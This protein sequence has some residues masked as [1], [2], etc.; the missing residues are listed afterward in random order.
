MTVLVIGLSKDPVVEKVLEALGEIGAEVVHWSPRDLLNDCAFTVRDGTVEGWLLVGERLV[1]LDDIL[2]IFNRFSS[3]EMTPEYRELA[4]NDPLAKHALEAGARLMQWCDIASCVVMNRSSSNDANSAKAYQAQLISDYFFVP[5]T[6]ITNRVE[7]ALE[8]ASLY[9]RTI[10]KSCSGERSIVTELSP[11]DIEAK[12]EALGNCPVQFQRHID[13]SDVRVHV[14]GEQTFAT[15]V[16]SKGA[17]YRYDRSAI[18]RATE[19][20]PAIAV[21]AVNMSRAMDLELAGIDL[22]LSN[23]GR[24]YCFEVNPSPAFSVYED[25]TNQKISHAVA[26]QLTGMGRP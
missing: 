22:R 4:A 16:T 23:D 8:L 13:G 25:A 21:T 24:A 10:F 26:L 12:A 2:G 9:E 7:S 11:A 20:E 14:V 19:I 6:R 17:D 18:W 1:N 15:T 5:E 3:I